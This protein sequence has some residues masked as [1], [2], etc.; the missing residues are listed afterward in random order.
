MAQSG[1]ATRLRRLAFKSADGLVAVVAAVA[2]RNAQQILVGQL[3]QRLLIP[4]GQ[5]SG[6]GPRGVGED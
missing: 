3:F 4:V 5:R 2:I 6:R 1:E